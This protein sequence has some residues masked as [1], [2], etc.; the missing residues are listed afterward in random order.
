[1]KYNFSNLNT[2]TLNILYKVLYNKVDNE[3]S[4]D[5]EE[6]MFWELGHYLDKKKAAQCGFSFYYD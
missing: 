5:T 6:V 3:T 1:M 2:E 4:T